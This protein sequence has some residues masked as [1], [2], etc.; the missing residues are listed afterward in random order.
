[1]SSFRIVDARQAGPTAV[2]VLIPPGRRTVVVVRPRTLDLDLLLVYRGEDGEPTAAFHE[3]GRAEAAMLA[4]NLQRHLL[5]SAGKRSCQT[6]VV[7]ATGADG[8]WVRAEVGAFLLI[9]CRRI[10]GQP[11]RPAVFATREEAERVAAAAGAALNP[12]EDA[13]LYVNADFFG[14]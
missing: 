13:E 9:A 14:R 8:F 1:M 3:A 2:G 10:A 7:P 4:E 6:E 5:Q 11:Y 12:G